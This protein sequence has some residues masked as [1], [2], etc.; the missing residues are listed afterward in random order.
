MIL[1]LIDNGL[2]YEENDQYPV[3][4]FYTQEG[5][6]KYMREHPITAEEAAKIFHDKWL[7]SNYWGSMQYLSWSVDVLEPAPGQ[8]MTICSNSIKIGE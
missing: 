7:A 6:E 3:G 4:L 5:V 2:S 1:L 8:P